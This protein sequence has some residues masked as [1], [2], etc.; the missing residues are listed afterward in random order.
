M[1]LTFRSAH[2]NTHHTVLFHL[3]WQLV[4]G[5]CFKLEAQCTH[6]KHTY[7]FSF[8]VLI[9]WSVAL[10]LDA[11]GRSNSEE[12]M[13]QNGI[14]RI[15]RKYGIWFF[16]SILCFFRNACKFLPSNSYVN[17]SYDATVHIRYAWNILALPLF[18]S[19]YFWFFRIASLVFC[20]T[21]RL[22]HWVSVV[23]VLSSEKCLQMHSYDKK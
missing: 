11:N 18:L 15:K 20:H 21:Q 13:H 17:K 1:H 7:S 10:K 23:R 6:D 4:A 3:L 14:A 12:R 22:G 9:W 5:S 19:F 8:W 2:R 16:D